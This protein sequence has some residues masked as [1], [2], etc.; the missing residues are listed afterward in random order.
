[1]GLPSWGPW[2]RG[3]PTSRPVRAR[4]GVVGAGGV[5]PVGSW[6]MTLPPG[7]SKARHMGGGRAWIQTSQLL[8][9]SRVHGFMRSFCVRRV[10]LRVV[11]RLRVGRGLLL[12]VGVV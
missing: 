1:H 6:L 7:M 4:P 10:L 8:H 12:G 3:V 9:S 11:W 5:C 2:C